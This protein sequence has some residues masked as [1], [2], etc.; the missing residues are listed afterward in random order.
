MKIDIL[1]EYQNS[2][3]TSA[4]DENPLLE[5]IFKVIQVVVT[6]FEQMLRS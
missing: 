5:A 4:E 6:V 3:K 1:Q 2:G